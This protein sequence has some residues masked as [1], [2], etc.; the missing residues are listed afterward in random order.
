[1]TY[2]KFER[3]VNRES[4]TRSRPRW[5]T[6]R[7][8][9]ALSALT[10]TAASTGCGKE[11]ARGGETAGHD[12][13]DDDG[14][15]DGEP[16]RSDGGLRA[17]DGGASS[18]RD[19][20]SSRSSGTGTDR[21]PSSGSPKDPTDEPKQL[22]T[23]D[24]C[25]ANNPA[26]LNTADVELLK[27]GGNASGLRYLYPY[28][29]TVFPRGLTPPLYMWE[30][31]N[32][33]AV[34]VRIRSKYFAYDGCFKPTAPG[35]L[36]VPASVW[37]MAGAQTLGP[38]TPFTVELTTLDGGR[39]LGPISQKLVIAQATIKGSIYYNSYDSRLAT[40]GAGQPGNPLGGGFP[41]IGGG[42]PGFGGGANG[43]VLRIKPG[44]EAEFFTRQGSC[45]G[46]HSLSA[47]GKRLIAMDVAG[48]GLAGLGGTGEN[49]RVYQL[50]PNT[51]ANPP[52]MSSAINAAFVALYPDGSL[53]LSTGATPAAAPQMGALGVV[54]ARLYETDTRMVIADSNIP[55]G[56]G[57]PTFSPDGT[58]LAFTDLA[59]GGRSVS[60]MKFD[61]QTRK[62]SDLRQVYSHPSKFV[63]WPFLLPDNGGVVV[64]V[65]DLNNFGGGGAYVAGSRMR[66]PG[67]DL[68]IADG[69]TKKGSLLA[70]AMGFATVEEAAQNKTYLPF[71]EVELHQN[72]YP[73]VSPVAA[74]G[75]FWVFFD[76]IRHYGNKGIHRALWATAVRV[77]AADETGAN[78]YDRDLSSPAFYLP[79][80]ELEAGNH[81]AFTALDPCRADGQSCEDGVDCCSGFCS[82][83]VCGPPE[84]ECS[85]TDESCKQD[86][87][88]CVEGDRCI[89]G[90]C[91]EV[92]LL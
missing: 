3:A 44:K 76:S 62:A 45:T 88:C 43:A 22:V 70:Q 37:T 27:R 16:S 57:M 59:A 17:S 75:Y 92:I 74:G 81:R 2:R 13:D 41:G 23:V 8:L 5:L 15:G 21:S 19:S 50:E 67:C 55:E 72:Y 6:L 52:P 66:G 49:G 64:T 39:A 83:G 65:G 20:G 24:E 18:K 36:Q 7:M 61:R 86:A 35:Q 54:P 58:R 10:T 89:G 40:G 4:G 69:S 53:Y 73:T 14:D 87:D 90:F 51:P 71:G 82:D 32:A 79:G 85:D 38:T 48:G 29:G 11:A 56:A 60:M 84:K 47:N 30:G 78:T 80:Q 26:G 46:C 63:G 25:G 91:G 33:S 68:Y 34:Y 42:F 77:L 9:A 12:D 31:G 1:M 28:D